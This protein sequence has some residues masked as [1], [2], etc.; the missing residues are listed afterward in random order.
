MAPVLQLPDFDRDFI[1]ECDVSGHGLGAVLHQG[2]GP[3]AFFSRQMAQ[4]HSKLVAYKRELIAL[5]QAVKH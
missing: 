5:V 2:S 1:V 4:R 3:V